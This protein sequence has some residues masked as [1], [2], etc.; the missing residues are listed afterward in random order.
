MRRLRLEATSAFVAPNRDG[1]RLRAAHLHK[2]RI[3][4]NLASVLFVAITRL[5]SSLIAPAQQSTPG[6]N[7][8][9]SVNEA[10]LELGV[11]PVTIRRR[12][13][14]GELAAVRIGT[15]GAVRIPS[16]ALALLIRP[17]SPQEDS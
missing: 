7:P 5:C 4:Q 10:A 8:L 11:S 1:R 2:N 3:L 13:A 16:A 17:Y 15:R 14:S 12:I 6:G 9:L